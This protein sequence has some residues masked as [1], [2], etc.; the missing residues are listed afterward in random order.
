MRP[1]T[2]ELQRGVIGLSVNQNQ[3]RP[4][5]TIPMVSPFPKKRMVPVLCSKWLILCKGLNER[6][7]MLCEKFP[8][9]ALR[10]A[11]QITLKS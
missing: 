9:L 1:E 2:N 5:V 11:F 4:D 10:F 6:R 3:I 8:V 7:K